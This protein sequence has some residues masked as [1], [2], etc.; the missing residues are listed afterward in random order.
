MGR[1]RKGDKTYCYVDK[2]T[3]TYGGANVSIRLQVFPSPNDLALE[4]PPSLQLKLDLSLGAIF[5][6]KNSYIEGRIVLEKL[7]FEQKG[8]QVYK[9][10]DSDLY[11]FDSQS[12]RVQLFVT[13]NYNL[14]KPEP[15]YWV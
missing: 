8:P 14:G 13:K 3:L 9:F 10:W 6:V 5:T 1:C 11:R 7:T 2:C 15:T 12:Y 4:P